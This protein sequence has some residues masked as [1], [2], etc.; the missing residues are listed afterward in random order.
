[1]AAVLGAASISLLAAAPAPAAPAAP[2]APG[3]VITAPT[4]A[5]LQLYVGCSTASSAEAAHACTLGEQPGAFFESSAE[6]EYEVC[7]TFP[8]ANTLC[9]PPQKAAANVLYVNPITTNQLGEHVVRWYVGG[10]EVAAWAFVV[11]PAPVPPTEAPPTMPPTSPAP[12]AEVEPAIT[13]ACAAART[14]E[15]HLQAHL[16]D[17]AAS[18]QRRHLRNRLRHARAVARRVCA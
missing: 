18:P 16:R 15:H 3:V 17:T 14:R 2:A 13:Q 8:S 4:T 12:P 7:V 1:M 6:L 10:V 5:T 11:E 9:P